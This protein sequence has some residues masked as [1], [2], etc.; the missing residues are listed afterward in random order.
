M[1]FQQY[2]LCV[3][4][5]G[6]WFVL[7]CQQSIE[8]HGPDADRQISMRNHA[9][10]RYRRSGAQRCTYRHLKSLKAEDLEKQS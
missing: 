4:N 9:W 10:K 8:Q 7:D 5:Q 3:V 1:Y 2:Q 6:L